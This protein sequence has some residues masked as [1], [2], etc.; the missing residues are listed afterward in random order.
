MFAPFN[1]IDHVLGFLPAAVR[2]GLYGLLV[3]IVAMLIYRWISP[4]KK[5]AALKLEIVESRR[6]MRS[7]TGTDVREML[8]LSTRS[9]TPALRQ[10]LLVLVPTLIAAA[11]VV[12]VV[13]WLGNAFSDR[14]V[15]SMGPDWLRTWH[16]P[17]MT[18]LTVAALAMKFTLKIH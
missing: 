2:L 14:P 11:P 16:T 10:L 8:R 12:F 5:L 6:A 3:G 4:Q 7:Y 18:A 17:F 13:L 9:I 1:A 15:W